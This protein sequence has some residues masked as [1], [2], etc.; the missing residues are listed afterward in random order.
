VLDQSGR[1]AGEAR[2]PKIADHPDNLPLQELRLTRLPPD[3][4]SVG[5]NPAIAR[6]HHDAATAPSQPTP[7]R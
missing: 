5:M 7:R 4:G 6:S 3:R 1:S 2:R